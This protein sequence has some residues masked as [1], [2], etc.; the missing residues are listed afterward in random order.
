MSELYW[1]QREQILQEGGLPALGEEVPGP[2][3]N[4]LIALLDQYRSSGG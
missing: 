2:V 1:H 4:A 3:R